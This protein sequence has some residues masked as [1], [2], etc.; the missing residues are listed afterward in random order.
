MKITIDELEK[1]YPLSSSLYND[2]DEFKESALNI[3]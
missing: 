2:D 3:N 1:I